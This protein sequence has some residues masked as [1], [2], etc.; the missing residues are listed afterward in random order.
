MSGAAYLARSDQV[1]NEISMAPVVVADVGGTTTDVCALFPRQAGTWVEIGGV[2]S[3]FSM[4]K[5]VSV[6]LGR[7]T[8]IEQNGDIVTV[9]PESVG[10]FLTSKALVFGG[11]VLTASDIVVAS[12]AAVIGDKSLVSHVSPKLVKEA[13]QQIKVI[14]EH[15]IEGMKL[16]AE[17]A[18]V[19]L[20]DG[21]SVVQIDT[22]DGVC[23]IIRPPFHDCANAVGAAMAK[24]SGEVDVVKILEGVNEGDIIEEVSTAAIRKT[25][26]AGAQ[27][28]TVKIVSIENMPFHPKT[29]DIP[30]QIRPFPDKDLV[31]SSSHVAKSNE[32]LS[33]KDKDPLEFTSSPSALI[34]IETYRLEVDENGT[35]WVS[36]V[37]CEFLATGCSV[38]ASGGGGPGYVCYLTARAAFKEGKRLSAVDINTVGFSAIL[39]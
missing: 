7:G 26:L 10:Y 32:I 25:V 28:E 34:D 33:N 24:V 39:Y 14:Q 2:R 29:L 5:V 38:S 30:P 4:P 21:G 27:L 19:I 36:E 8:K 16:I 11:D 13:R 23:E 3:A 1:Q 12:Q 31:P 37:D 18:I 22:L 17:D 35:W 20:V 6:S 9:G 15:A